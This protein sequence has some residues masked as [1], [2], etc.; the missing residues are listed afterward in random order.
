MASRGKIVGGIYDDRLLVNMDVPKM[1]DDGKTVDELTE[2]INPQGSSNK[3]LRSRSCCP[4]P[5]GGI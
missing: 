5:R 2:A 3:N 1:K 4:V